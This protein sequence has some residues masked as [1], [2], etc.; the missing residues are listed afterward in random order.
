MKT[1]YNNVSLTNA[2]LTFKKK[3][4]DSTKSIE[5]PKYNSLYLQLALVTFYSFSC[6][7]TFPCV[8]MTDIGMATAC[9]SCKSETKVLLVLLVSYFMRLFPQVI[10]AIFSL[11]VKTLKNSLQ[12]PGI[13]CMSCT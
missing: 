12:S 5:V 8:Q 11:N 3:L 9:A 7:E 10:Q 6:T 2:K 1:A 4:L 13:S